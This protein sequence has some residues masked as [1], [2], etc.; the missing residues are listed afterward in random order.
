MIRI[1]F[2]AI[3][4]LTVVASGCSSDAE[5]PQ[6]ADA[7]VD[8]EPAADAGVDAKLYQDLA[9]LADLTPKAPCES[10]WREAISPQSSPSGAAVTTTAAGDVHTTLI[11][12]SAG[13]MTEAHL[14]PFVYLSLQS[15]ARV[16]LD[17]LTAKDDLSWDL[18]F[19]RTVIR[20]NG[21]DSGSGQGAVAIVAGQTFE[22]LTSAPAA[23]A[24]ASD[25]FLD[26]QCTIVRD[27]VNAI[28][29]AFDGPTGMWYEYD[30]STS[31]VTPKP[32]V[33]VV[34]RATGEL[35]KLVI[36]SYYNKS[37]LGAHY[38]IRWSA[39]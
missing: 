22:T 3:V 38:T 18:A 12:A 6:P 7:A 25:D 23:S 33:Y 29:T 10:E 36:D 8:T 2:V 27:P 19:R 4:L 16:D 5:D 32:L 28:L 24:F 31:K 35:V 13:G 17:D 34:R 39:L 1:S 9:P 37:G 11:D 20:V 14:H 26:E 30:S 21:G 15:G